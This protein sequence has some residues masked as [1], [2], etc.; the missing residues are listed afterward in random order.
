MSVLYPIARDAEAA[1]KAP[2]GRAVRER[3][4]LALAGGAELAFVRELTGPSYATREAAEAAWPGLVD[5]EG[6]PGVQ[7]EDRFC[8]LMEIIEPAPR[9]GGGQAE[10]TFAAGSRWPKP[11][12]RLKTAWRLQVSYWKLLDPEAQR[13]LPQARAARRSQEAQALD[14]KALRTMAGQPLQAVK[15]QQPLDIGLFEYTLP[16][17]PHLTIPDE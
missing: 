13:A 6:A 7:P 9:A 2:A 1:L 15:P 11:K 3:E 5:R 14:A 17:A 8:E 10:P 12:K 16:E 4:A